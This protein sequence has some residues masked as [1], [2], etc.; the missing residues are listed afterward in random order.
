MTNNI[1][2]VIIQAI[3]NKILSLSESLNVTEYIEDNFKDEYIFTYSN[4]TYILERKKNIIYLRKLMNFEM[5]IKNKVESSSFK[6]KCY[7]YEVE[8]FTPNKN[9]KSAIMNLNSINTTDKFNNELQKLGHF[10]C[11]FTNAQTQK[12]I[13]SLISNPDLQTKYI[14]ETVGKITV[15][16]Q[17]YWNTKDKTYNYK[18]SDNV[19]DN[20]QI[21]DTIKLQS[22]ISIIDTVN[23]NEIFNRL[24]KKSKRLFK[25]NWEL[26]KVE[27]LILAFFFHISV[28]Y[29]H[30]VE[31]FMLVGFS[32]SS[33][34]ADTI[35]E[36]FKTFPIAYLE[37]ESA[38]GK[39]NLCR[40]VTYMF[41]LDEKFLN[42]GNDTVN[43]IR[44]TLATYSNIPVF[45]TE[46]GQCK[47]SIGESIIKPVADRT[48]RNKMSAYGKNIIS[49]P[50]LG[51][52]GLCLN[53]PIS[54]EPAISNRLLQMYF[55]HSNFRAFNAKIF[56]DLQNYL[57]VI[58]PEIIK[59]YKKEDVI[60]KINYYMY[61][62]LLTNINEIRHK[63]NVA[64][65]FA[66]LDLLWSLIP[67]A[68]GIN[69]DYFINK[70]KYYC[71]NYI[72]LSENDELEKFI[73]VLSELIKNKKISNGI[74][75]KILQN[76]IHIRTKCANFEMNFKT[77]Y[78]RCYQEHKP[79]NINE[80]FKLLKGNGAERK[81]V[82]YNSQKTYSGIFLE[83]SNFDEL[84]DLIKN[85]LYQSDIQSKE[86]F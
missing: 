82:R 43:S 63:T 1:K 18:D 3:N 6:E 34:F 5:I 20:F 50:V 47:K 12:F 80:Y 25:C 68:I 26:S 65:A 46:L 86:V 76:G 2:N 35:F 45:L 67:N 69:I 42:G 32:I 44:E 70:V 8:I 10:H 7:A 52:L 79:L 61:N 77:H 85:E 60:N 73:V 66:G 57:S 83:F 37:G 21:A 11:V 36:Q 15:N 30:S 24:V 23:S 13:A 29:R 59:K 54:K 49:Y 40:L 27:S 72:K 9:S 14:F 4:E 56:N 17:D 22:T 33:I 58:V 51:T 75:I 28:T 53:D 48:S 19:L 31:P 74:E 38:S 78:K 84:L 16:K 64:I 39:S 55:K 71:D 62:D 81:T 41:G